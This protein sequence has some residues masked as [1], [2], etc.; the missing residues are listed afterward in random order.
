MNRRGMIVTT[1]ALL[2][3]VLYG[4]NGELEKKEPQFGTKP[5]FPDVPTYHFVV[6]PLH[7]P[8]KLMQAYQPLIDYLN[9]RLHGERLVLEA[10]R[11][12]AKFEEKYR[13]RKPDFLLP[14]PWQTLQAMKVNY[15]VI[16]MAGDPQDF[17]GIFV[18]R[19]DSDLKHITDLKG[20]SVSYP[21]RTALAACIMPQYLLFNHGININTDIENHYVGSQE[22]AI[23]NAYLRQTAAGATWP[24]P[25]RAFQ[26][27]HPR[28]AAELKVIWET[29]S[30]VNNSV[31]VRNDVP[32][33]VREQVRVFLLGLDAT[34]EGK[35]VLARM[36]TARFLPASDQ[37]YDVVRQYISRFEREVRRVEER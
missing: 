28:V 20:K 27:Q 6:H 34:K 4:C 15:H 3:G 11:D 2:I 25:W 35:L 31:M 29:E 9:R 12:Y 21:S 37:D 24:P 17:K 1:L 32:A 23:M 26:K 8:A 13:A 16:A 5:F 19:K 14:N 30:L 10:S 18:V 33:Q 22:S 36:E 7:N